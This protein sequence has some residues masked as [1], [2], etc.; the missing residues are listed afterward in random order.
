[1]RIGLVLKDAK[2][3]G[4]NGCQR[5]FGKA[6]HERP[7]IRTSGDLRRRTHIQAHISDFSSVLL[8]NQQGAIALSLDHGGAAG[9]MRTVA[10]QN[11][12]P[13][14]H[15]QVKCCSKS[16]CGSSCSLAVKGAA[17]AGTTLTDAQWTTTMLDYWHTPLLTSQS[18][19]LAVQ[20]YACFPADAPSLV[21][22]VWCRSLL[23]KQ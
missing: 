15:I 10:G 12:E 20:N 3:G 17:A 16:V 22:S 5:L 13:R 11:V 2:C 9:P 21:A 14:R 1:M 8:F 4:L 18:A 6:C 19:T 23:L 7:Y